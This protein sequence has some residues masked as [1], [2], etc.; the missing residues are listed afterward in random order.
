MEKKI[1]SVERKLWRENRRNNLQNFESCISLPFS[2]E[3][4]IWENLLISSWR[5]SFGSK[6]NSRT[7]SS[8]FPLIMISE[9]P[10]TKR[11]RSKLLDDG[12][13]NIDGQTW[14][15]KLY[16]KEGIPFESL[17]FPV[18]RERKKERKSNISQIISPSFDDRTKFR[19][20]Y[21]TAIVKSTVKTQPPHFAPVEFNNGEFTRRVSSWQAVA[22]SCDSGNEVLT[23]PTFSPCH[24]KPTGFTWRS[25]Y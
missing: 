19:F 12:I 9:V 11:K 16:W 17:F 23:A 15:N 3:T 7:F 5:R 21:E 6:R 1:F 24:R 22:I 2:D 8:F 10:R 20:K 4:I 14:Y 25:M 13:V 18:K